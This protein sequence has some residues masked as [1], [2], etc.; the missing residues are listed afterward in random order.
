MSMCRVYS[1][2]V[3]NNVNE[4]YSIGS[5]SGLGEQPSDENLLATSDAK[6]DNVDLTHDISLTC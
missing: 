4:W 1:I 3:S 2:Y 5:D 6:G